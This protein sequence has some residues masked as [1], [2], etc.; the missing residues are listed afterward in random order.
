MTP[1]QLLT[2]ATVATEANISRAAELLHL[3][4]PAVSGQLRLLQESFGQPLYRRAGR[5]IELTAAG[6]QLAVLAKQLQQT[7]QRAVQLRAALADL[8]IGTI[9]LGASTTPASYVLPHLLAEFRRQHS[10]INCALVTGNT[11]DICAHLARFDI[12]FIEGPVPADLPRHTHILPWHRD[13]IV[14]I[15]PPG[16]PL[17]ALATQTDSAWPTLALKDLTPWPLVLRE[18]GSGVRQQVLQALTEAEIEPNITIELAGVEGIKEGVRAGLGI[19]FVSAMS[20]QRPD[21]SLQALRIAHPKPLERH[22]TILIPH[23]EDISPLAQIFL[24]LCQNHQIQ[25]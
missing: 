20:M 11:T 14:A 15:V 23:A 13:E 19:G 10:R 9:A 24:S 25:P 6:Q 4:Q 1:D 12:A 8:Q 22:L 7:Y 5:G 21:P 2:F 3:S 17:V 18:N 16:H